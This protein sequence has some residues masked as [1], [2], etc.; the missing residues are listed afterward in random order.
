[1]AKV[2]HLLHCNNNLSQIYKQVNYPSVSS[3]S[4]D[5]KKQMGVS[6]RDYLK[7]YKLPVQE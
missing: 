4:R 3:L 1:M 5:F 6:P 2:V 7:D